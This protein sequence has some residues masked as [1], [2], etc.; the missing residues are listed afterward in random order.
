MTN[1]KTRQ[2]KKNSFCPYP[3]TLLTYSLKNNTAIQPLKSYHSLP[4]PEDFF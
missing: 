1:N 4:F 3:K 2:I